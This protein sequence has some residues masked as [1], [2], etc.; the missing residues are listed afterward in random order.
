MCSNHYFMCSR[1]LNFNFGGRS[2]ST[3]IW[4]SR[5]FVSSIQLSLRCLHMI[6]RLHSPSL[7]VLFNKM[8]FCLS[9]YPAVPKYFFHF[10]YCSV[11]SGIYA[12]MFLEHWKSPRSSMCSLFSADDIPN[13]RIKLSNDMFF[14]PRNTGKKDPVITYEHEEVTCV[15]AFV[16][17]SF[18]LRNLSY[19]HPFTSW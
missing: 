16:L 11:D 19:I 6:G 5:I 4:S 13:I 2:L 8:S 15:S 3:M 12:M 7:A 9:N 18:F 1:S 10:L 17:C 14:N